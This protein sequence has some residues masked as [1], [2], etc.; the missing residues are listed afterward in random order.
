M[1]HSA[2]AI[3]SK[4]ARTARPRRIRYHFPVG[5]ETPKSPQHRKHYRLVEAKVTS[6]LT[7]SAPGLTLAIPSLT[8]VIPREAEGPKMVSNK[9]LE[10]V[11]GELVE[12]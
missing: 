11:R 6:G 4:M 2:S 12:P 1:I 5:L 7:P 3:R 8:L 9:S 10:T